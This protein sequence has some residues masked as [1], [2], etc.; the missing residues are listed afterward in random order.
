MNKQILEVLQNKYQD[1]YKNILLPPPVFV[2][3]GGEIL[4][5]DENSMIIKIM[6]PLKAIYANPFWKNARRYRSC[7]NR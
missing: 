1:L 5:Y 3:M 7:S 2:E 4:E 6:Y